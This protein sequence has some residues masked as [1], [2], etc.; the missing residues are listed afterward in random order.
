[1][2]C[3]ARQSRK[4]GSLP[5]MT[6][7]LGD[8]TALA[9]FRDRRVPERFIRSPDMR[10]PLSTTPLPAWMPR[11]R[12]LSYRIL[13]GLFRKW[14]RQASTSPV[15]PLRGSSSRT[16][17]AARSSAVPPQR[18]DGT[19]E[20]WKS[21]RLRCT[22]SMLRTNIYAGIGGHAMTGRQFITRVRSL[23]MHFDAAAGPG[24]HGT[25]HLDNR[26]TTVKDRRKEIGRGLLY[27][28]LDDLGIAR[29]EFQPASATDIPCQEECSHDSH[30]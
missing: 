11:S 15:R 13:P 23:R 27:R 2:A 28:I 5:F 12:H 24:S 10:Q 17:F 20:L 19:F 1:M 9:P 4:S 22:R 29:N 6:Q 7:D 3:L 16:T 21:T 18:R 26:R 25:L 30:L 8:I 14:R